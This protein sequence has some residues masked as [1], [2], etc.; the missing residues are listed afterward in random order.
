MDDTYPYTPDYIKFSDKIFLLNN[1]LQ[2]EVEFE[3]DNYLIRNDEF[4]ITVWGET[5]EEAVEAFSFSFYSLYVNFHNE[6]DKNLS[7]GAQ[8][9]KGKLKSI[10]KQVIDEA[11]KD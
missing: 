9:L 6:S 7:E 10:I 4:D 3:N 11:K 5:R 2:C 1:E 8:S